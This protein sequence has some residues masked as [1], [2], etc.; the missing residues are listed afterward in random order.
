[1]INTAYTLIVA[2]LILIVS[3]FCLEAALA[4]ITIDANTIHVETNNY[5]VQFDRGVI[6][7]NPQQ[8]HRRHLHPT[9]PNEP[10]D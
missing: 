6:T 9:T 2:M 4:D 7:P 5:K 1:M 3:L 8:T 10:R